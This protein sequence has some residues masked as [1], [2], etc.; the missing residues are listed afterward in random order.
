MGE[1]QSKLEAAHAAKREL[2]QKEIDD[3]KNQLERKNKDHEKLSAAMADLKAANEQL[4][5]S[6]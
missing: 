6:F 3:L 5:V 1:T 2:Q 4:Q